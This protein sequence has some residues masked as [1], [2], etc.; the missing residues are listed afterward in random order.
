MQWHSYHYNRTTQKMPVDWG[1][2]YGPSTSMPLYPSSAG[3]NFAGQ[4]LNYQQQIND[5]QMFYDYGP[6]SMNSYGMN[7]YG[8]NSYASPRGY[9]A[10]AKRL[11]TGGS[12]SGNHRSFP[13]VDRFHTGT[14]ASSFPSRFGSSDP[15]S[16]NNVSQ[17]RQSFWS[18][19]KNTGYRNKETVNTDES[20]SVLRS[21]IL[22]ELQGHGKLEF[23]VLRRKLG[24]VKRELNQNLYAMEKQGLV[25]K[26]QSQ[27][28]VWSATSLSFEST[29]DQPYSQNF[30][31]PGTLEAPCIVVAPTYDTNSSKG[32]T[33]LYRTQNRSNAL[34]ELATD[35]VPRSPTSSVKLE[36]L[37]IDRMECD[38]NSEAFSNADEASDS[39]LKLCGSLYAGTSRTC[40]EMA[41]TA[42]NMMHE[43]DSIVTVGHRIVEQSAESFSNSLPLGSSMQT[44]LSL[45]KGRGV[46][47]HISNSSGSQR[48]GQTL[49]Q[50]A[51]SELP[52]HFV[53]SQSYSDEGAYDSDSGKPS[54]V[55]VERDGQMCPSKSSC[56]ASG[57]FVL[58]APPRNCKLP[59]DGEEPREFKIPP[60]PKQLIRSNPL[61]S[62]GSSSLISAG[63]AERI[64]DGSFNRL[65]V[66]ERLPVSVN[67]STVSDSESCAVSRSDVKQ[68]LLQNY[69]EYGYTSLPQGLDQLSVSGSDW[70]TTPLSNVRSTVQSQP[71]AFNSNPF[72]A[73]LG[74]TE[75]NFESVCRSLNENEL[76]ANI[77]RQAAYSSSG[78]A[79]EEPLMN[80]TNESFAAL[81]KN[82]VSAL[83]E[84][85]Q[86]RKLDV[87]IQCI[88]CSGPP[89]K[90]TFK[91]AVCI[92][93]RWF[94]VAECTNKKDG[95]SKA[96]DLALRT[97]LAEGSYQPPTSLMFEV[98]IGQSA[99]I[100]DKIASLAHQKFNSL[101]AM[102]TESMVGKKVLA[103]LIMKTS[104]DDVGRV[105]SLGLGN[106]CI[107]GTFLSLEGQTV[108][109][110]HAEIIT[111]R[112]FI[113]FLYQQLLSY[114]TKQTDTIFEPSKGKLKVKDG[115][116]FHLY[117]STAPCGDGSLFSP[118][119]VASSVEMETLDTHQPIFT[120]KVQGLLRTKMEGGE[121]T[122][123]L[124]DKSV[125]QTWDGILRGER[126][127]TMSCSDKVCRWNILGLQGALL[128]HFIEPVYV[129]SLTLGFL[130]DYGHLSRAV[131]CRLSH[132]EPDISSQLPP[133]YRINHPQLGRV[134]VTDPQ[135]ETQ[136]TKELSLNWTYGDSSIELTDGTK[137]ICTSSK[138]GQTS[139]VAKCR[140][141]ESFKTAC[142]AFQRADL[143][144]CAS[145]K[146]AKEIAKDFQTAKK[147]MKDKF[148]ARGY[149]TWLS[150]PMEEDM[151]S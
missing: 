44:W 50:H 43:D 20:P 141:Y 85:G 17:D 65:R 134:T 62:S 92:G 106:R 28:P 61:Y 40:T 137:G 120:S 135:R 108:N 142:K 110:S 36:A 122:I 21:L 79:S 150:K 72:A 113:R 70:K 91:M 63:S 14:S 75:D 144:G 67:S 130:F 99:T 55:S 119:D 35:P 109:D 93:N 88:G 16:R 87:Q 22:K 147:L 29:R 127:R 97:L 32:N 56:I 48:V 38:L 76:K 26:I 37:E 94:P 39:R 84:Y 25:K 146:E 83:M 126:L 34:K 10:R 98:V 102:V 12:F 140:L 107:T 57:R 89:H 77:S 64:G 30:P 133:G 27:P 8:K 31:V 49:H 52:S 125:S 47:K 18:K 7:Y 104:S 95:K 24:V 2:G 5:Q 19:S 42:G 117:I 90:P 103:A 111:R 148:E 112:G 138:H 60:S 131:C 58:P 11:K 9:N 6:T 74:L 143:L 15:V 139:Q 13:Q 59:S 151:F 1:G 69:G 114:T 54:S 124:E 78:S 41:Q 96:A 33:D 68:N 128:S 51:S 116:T 118:R 80:L 100:F 136:K 46:T 149:G 132:G 23:E 121:G 3:G 66:G 145:Y 45:S 53:D 123:P 4:S 105:V 115:I 71:D 81:N 82:S 129:S 86:S 101:A 73:S